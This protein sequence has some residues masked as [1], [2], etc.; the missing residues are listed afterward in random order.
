MASVSCV[1]LKK[2]IS[3]TADIQL[4][5]KCSLW[6][7]LCACLHKYASVQM[8]SAELFLVYPGVIEGCHSFQR[9]S[10]LTNVKF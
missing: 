3:E 1:R 10:T 2:H 6:T 5:V 7:K 4:R 8:K 9:Q